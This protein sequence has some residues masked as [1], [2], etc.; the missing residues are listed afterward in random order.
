MKC[1]YPYA[2]FDPKKFEDLEKLFTKLKGSAYNYKRIEK[3]LDEIEKIALIS[4]YE[5]INAEIDEKISGENI[6]F[7]FNIK[8]SEKV[9]VEKLIYL[10]TI[11]LMRNLYEIILLLMRAILLIKFYAKLI[12][13]LKSTGIFKSINSEILDTKESDKKI[14]NLEIEEKP[15]GEISASAG[16]G[17]DEQ[18]LLLVLKITLMVKE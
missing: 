7:L 1:N 17:T 10:E 2:D 11:L 12:N 6:N 14:I 8:E 15:T 3:I 4:N 13:N 18:L 16:V 9:F 5:F